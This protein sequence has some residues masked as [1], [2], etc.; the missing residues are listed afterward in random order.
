MLTRVTALNTL[1]ASAEHCHFP[2]YHDEY[3][4]QLTAEQLMSRTVRGYRRTEWQKTRERNEALDCRVYARAAASIGGLDR[5][6]EDNW[7][8][9]ED[10][11]RVQ[12]VESA[13][14]VQPQ[15]PPKRDSWFN[16]NKRTDRWFSGSS[17][18]I[19]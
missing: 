18:W 9:F 15:Q 17:G 5:F 6:R 8:D 14:P 12:P 7:K 11:V 13:V 2:K 3:F 1:P 19:R 4:K 16:V 10:A